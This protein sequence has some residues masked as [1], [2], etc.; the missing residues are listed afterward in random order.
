MT[1]DPDLLVVESC[2]FAHEAHL[3]RSALQSIGIKAVIADEHVVAMN[4]ALAQAVGGIKVKVRSADLQR[5]RDF[6]DQRRQ[7]SGSPRR[8]PC[9]RCR[10]R[11]TRIIRTGRGLA[12]L[13]WF[14]TGQPL[15]TLRT[16]V[17]CVDCGRTRNV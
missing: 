11:N 2:K 7:Q 12:V 14:F 13:F 17:R 10:S 4:W 8:T 6:L 16:R 3:V 15:P 1:S 5:A 9:D